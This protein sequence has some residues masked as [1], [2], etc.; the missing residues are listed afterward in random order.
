MEK[1][2]LHDYP[3]NP[4]QQLMDHRME[5]DGIRVRVR[6]LVFDTTHHTWEPLSALAEDVPELV[7]E[8]LYSKKGDRRCARALR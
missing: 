6:W 7:E 5:N 4:V 1:A 3:E 8:Y 2:A